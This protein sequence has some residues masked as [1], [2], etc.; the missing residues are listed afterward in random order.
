[1]RFR[2]RTVILVLLL[3][4]TACTRGSGIPGSE[5][6]ELGAFEGVEVHGALGVTVTVGSTVHMEISGDDN[7]VPL[8]RSEVRGSTLVLDLPG[9]ISTELPLQVVLA[10][11]ALGQLDV[12]GASTVDVTG[13]SGSALEVDVSGASTVS[14]A[15]EVES[16]DAEV[17]G[18]S[19]LRAEALSAVRAEVDAGGASTVTVRVGE[20]LSAE[21]SGASTIRYHGA[22]AQVSEDS[23]GASTIRRVD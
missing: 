23:S 14:L 5:T 16:L 15:G 13:V 20:S 2:P 18:A 21:A 19:Q 3:A 12:E 9:R 10:T 6:R 17:S 4:A 8:V 22:P 7:I 1:M 11:P